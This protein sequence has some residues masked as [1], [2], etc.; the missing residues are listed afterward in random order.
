MTNAE[1]GRVVTN[2]VSRLVKGDD[3]LTGEEIAAAEH[4][5]QT[6]KVLL[7]APVDQAPVSE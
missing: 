3:T 7:S 6:L 5:F 4:A 2:C 1:L